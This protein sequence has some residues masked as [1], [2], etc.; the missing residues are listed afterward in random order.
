MFF[1]PMPV[2]VQGHTWSKPTTMSPRSSSY[3]APGGRNVRAW[4]FQRQFDLG[5]SGCR[6]STPGSRHATPASDASSTKTPAA[7]TTCVPTAWPGSA[8]YRTA[9]DTQKINGS[10][11]HSV[12]GQKGPTTQSKRVRRHAPPAAGSDDAGS[13]RYLSTLMWP[14]R[15]AP[16]HLQIAREMLRQKPMNAVSGQSSPQPSSGS[17]SSQPPGTPL[18]TA[19]SPA[20]VSGRGSSGGGG[21]A[22][23]SASSAGRTRGCISSMGWRSSASGIKPAQRCSPGDFLCGSCLRALGACEG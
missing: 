17:G 21:G 10:V 4:S 7:H 11:T 23:T 14:R 13:R 8:E 2:P 19:Y 15:F 18:P 12:K 3:T 9:P 16:T 6:R 20:S 5:L 1:S 22:S